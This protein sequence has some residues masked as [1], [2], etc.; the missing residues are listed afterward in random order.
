MDVQQIERRKRAEELA[1]CRHTVYKKRITV[2]T[3]S[4]FGGDFV[5]VI[6]R[7]REIAWHQSVRSA[8]RRRKE[9]RKRD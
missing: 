5:S 8:A 7:D 2:R 3:K 4:Y 9:Q 1:I 6:N